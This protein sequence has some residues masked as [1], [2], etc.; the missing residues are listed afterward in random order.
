MP[1]KRKAR[2]SQIRDGAFS[3]SP[4]CFGDPHFVTYD[5]TH[6]NFQQAGEFLLTKST[7]AADPFEVDIQIR[8]WRAGARGAI[9]SA[10]AVELCNHR[11]IFDVDRAGAENFVWVDGR[12]SSLSLADPVL[13]LGACTIDEHSAS[14]YQV[15][16]DTDEIL[17][18]SDNGAGLTV[19]SW[20]APGHDPGAV[21]GLLGSSDDPEAW[22]VTDATSLFDAD[23]AVPEPGSLTLLGAGLVGLFMVRRRAVS[24]STRPGAEAGASCRGA[25]G[26]EPTRT[27]RGLRRIANF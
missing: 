7:V 1:R 3:S 25:E 16:W 21:E 18:V 8:P 2:Y 17:D 27:A 14:D 19:S 13:T 22:R 4:R 23:T 10:A 9:V 12:S 15:F 24:R 20:L 26:W 5:G 11:A 6:Y